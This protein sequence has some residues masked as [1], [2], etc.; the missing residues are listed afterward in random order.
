MSSNLTD[1]ARPFPIIPNKEEA[2]VR[3]GEEVL[4]LAIPFNL[5]RSGPPLCKAKGG[6]GG[7]AKVPYMDEG[8]DGAGSEDVEMVGMKVD[9]GNGPIVAV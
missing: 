7:V 6:P 1:R 3:R 8:V 4:I 9:V 2:I 5:G